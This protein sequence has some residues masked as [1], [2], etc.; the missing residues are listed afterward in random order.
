[1]RAGCSVKD[2]HNLLHDSPLLKKSCA[3]QVVLD[4]WL[5]LISARGL[6]VLSPRLLG[7]PP[8]LLRLPG[9]LPELPVL[10]VQ[11]YVLYVMCVLYEYKCYMYVIRYVYVICML[12][13]CYM[14]YVICMLYVSPRRPRTA[15]VLIL[16]WG[17]LLGWLETRLAQ[18]TFKYLNIA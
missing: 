14:L 13:V 12:Y 4:E 5:P 15:V 8:A 7:L 18:S 17:C 6:A 10:G 1:M 3:R 2:H 16:I 11:S 9:A